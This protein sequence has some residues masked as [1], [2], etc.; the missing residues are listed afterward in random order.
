MI[1]HVLMHDPAVRRCRIFSTGHAPGII[2][3]AR[4]EYSVIHNFFY[5]PVKRGKKS[6][7]TQRM[8]GNLR[9]RCCSQPTTFTQLML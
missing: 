6:K 5:E 8:L 4:P 3:H 9:N 2:G 7:V 1:V